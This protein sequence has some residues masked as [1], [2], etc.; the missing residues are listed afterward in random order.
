MA[1]KGAQ[2]G[3]RIRAGVTLCDGDHINACDHAFT[4]EIQVP[5]G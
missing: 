4:F 1:E 3:E 5:E 2:F